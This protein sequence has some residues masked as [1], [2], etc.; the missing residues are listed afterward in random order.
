MYAVIMVIRGTG[1]LSLTAKSF[2]CS[3]AWTN[4][5]RKCLLLRRVENRVMPSSTLGLV[6][7]VA[8]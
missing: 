1:Y 4:V 5:M 7:S 3:K 6:V 2:C 8:W